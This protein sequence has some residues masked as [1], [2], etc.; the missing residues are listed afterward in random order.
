MAKR[1]KVETP[2]ENTVVEFE[3]D[4]VTKN[5]IR[6]KEVQEKENERPIMGT[7]YLRKDIAKEAQ[8]IRLTIER[9]EE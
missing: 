1:T 6:Y 7:V 5:T 4:K 9:V 2:V 8:S 3:L